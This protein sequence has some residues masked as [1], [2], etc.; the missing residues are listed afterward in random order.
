[1]RRAQALLMRS[2]LSDNGNM[3]NTTR[4]GRRLLES[5]PSCTPNG[6]DVG[7][8]MRSQQAADVVNLAVV[9][10]RQLEQM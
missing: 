9:D 6:G 4:S 5:R 1:M 8:G 10:G 7:L 2:Y 3:L